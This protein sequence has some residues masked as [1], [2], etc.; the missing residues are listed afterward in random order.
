[1]QVQRPCLALPFEGVDVLTADAVAEQVLARNPSLAQMT[2][3]WEAASAR[4]PQV[5]SLDDP[6]LGFMLA[7]QSIGSNT[8]DF[9]FRAEVSQKIPFPGKRGLRGASAEAEA[10]AASRDVADMRLQLIEAAKGA[11]FDYYLAHR[12]IR[13]NEEDLT[14]LKAA[15]KAAENRIGAGKAN[16]QE[17]LQIDVEEGRQRERGLILLRMKK[18]AA[19][20]INTLTH[21]PPDA[22]L[23]PPPEQV[24]LGDSLPPAEEL[25]SRALAVRPD[26]Q[27]LAD[28]I[29]SEE[30][31]LALARREFCPDAEFTAAYDSIMGNGPTR[32]L[33]LQ[34]GVRVNLPIRTERR[35]AA[36]AE[37]AARIASRQ[38]ELARLTDQVHFQVQEAFE[39]TAESEKVV[40][41]YKE[42]ILQA[43]E[44]NAEAALAAYIPGQIPLLS[45]LEARRN[46]VSVRDR[47][48][49][50]LADYHR[51]RATLER[52][53]GG[54]L[55]P[56][57]L[58]TPSEPLKTEK[59]T[60][61]A[62]SSPTVR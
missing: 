56:A 17:A 36:V 1:V 9:G 52:V 5:T 35:R 10:S 21:S 24:S 47:Y 62:M 34:F 60:T 13:V 31:M 48:Y 57:T 15:R 4:I 3:T 51:R 30:A 38:A 33:A 39:Q 20:R 41:L 2:A 43:A 46:L 54:P 55:G 58:V 50:A 14:L 22:P 25:R 19:A 16:R 59:A 7:P 26:L 61:P 44:N 40:R 49:E 28:R 42:T 8:V 29:R 37:A 18:V 23:P 6:D 53:T 32:D 12:A 45:L 27:A 11:F